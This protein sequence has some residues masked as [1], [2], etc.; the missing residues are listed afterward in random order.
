MKIRATAFAM[1]LLAIALPL[2]AAERL[3]VKTG[4]WDS[5]VTMS[6]VAPTPPEAAKLSPAQRAQMEQMMKQM[7][8]GAPRTISSQSCITTKDLEGNAF[9]T[10]LEDAGQDCAFTQVLGTPKRQEFTFQCRSPDGEA[11]GRMV[12]DV[13]SDTRVRGTMD[14]K[15][16]NGSLDLKFE[17]T[18]KSADC[19]AVKPG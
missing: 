1:S 10:S 8:I 2:L 15:T 4:L 17:A 19:G 6:I 12:I 7:G 16:P 11:S 5:N 3:A 9:G 13:V 18:W 14:A